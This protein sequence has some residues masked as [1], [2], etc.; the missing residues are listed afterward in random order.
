MGHLALCE[1]KP[2]GIGFF[3]LIVGIVLLGA[4]N[5]SQ[6]TQEFIDQPEA[7]RGFFGDKSGPGVGEYLLVQP[8][9]A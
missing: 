5:K 2:D 7:N 4:T 8:L 6:E 3:L 1:D 9:W